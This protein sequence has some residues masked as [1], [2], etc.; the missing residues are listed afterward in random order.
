MKNKKA[1]IAL[2]LILGFIIV[3]AVSFTLYIKNIQK[4]D[5]IE[6]SSELS[7]EFQPVKN[8]IESC[9]DKTSKEGLYIIGYQGGYISLPE[10]STFELIPN[11]P[12]YAYEGMNSVPEREVIES[13]LNF[14]IKNELKSC[15]EDFK[16]L[17]E[18]G[19]LINLDGFEIKSNINEDVVVEGN[20]NLYIEKDGAKQKLEKTSTKIYIRIG[21]LHNIAKKIINLQNQSNINLYEL[22]YLAHDNNISING[23][24]LGDGITTFAI[25]DNTTYPNQPYIYRF[26]TKFRLNSTA[27]QPPSKKV[28]IERIPNQVLEQDYLFT[29]KVNAIGNN[30]KF[31]D[32]TYLFDINQ[33]TGTINFAP[34]KEH[35]GKHIVWVGAKDSEG[36]EDLA[37]FV[38]E[39]KGF[40]SKPK[41]TPTFEQKAK[42]GAQFFYDFNA[43]DPD[44]DT[45]FF[46]DNSEFLNIG[47]SDGIV[48]FIPNENQLGVY[49]INI[50]VVDTKGAVDFDVFKLSI[51]K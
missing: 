17:K 14:Y 16:I 18:L 47:L 50:T 5:L 21:V 2:F 31:F 45:L 19:Y 44:N 48:R 13:E 33:D 27:I 49:D 22:T 26:A 4:N 35:T 37:S 43:T 3:I 42:V 41:L 39:V 38:V 29:Y 11:I 32:Y 36:N 30:L 23:D 28:I 8:F 15:F 9:I 12:Y 51:E 40:N 10:K 34:T 25:I 20:F 46:N 6:K 1:Q 7:V 24:G